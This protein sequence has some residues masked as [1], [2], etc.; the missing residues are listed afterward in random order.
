MKKILSQSVLV[1]FFGIL[2]F[3]VK[4][5]LMALICEYEYGSAD[6][7]ETNTY[8]FDKNEGNTADIKHR[9]EGDLGGDITWNPSSIIIKY[10]YMKFEWEI[11]TTETI[12]R[13]DLSFK[14]QQE[15]YTSDGVRD[16][17]YRTTGKCQVTTVPKKENAF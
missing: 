5:E 4:G 14:S 16:G 8:I 11:R 15:R 17:A 12:N 6:N 2:S 3:P 9:S 7:I 1:L 10:S 13:S